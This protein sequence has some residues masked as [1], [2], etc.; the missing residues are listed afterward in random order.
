MLPCAQGSPY[1]FVE[2]LLAAPLAA[3]V[4]K[5]CMHVEFG[6]RHAM[7]KASCLLSENFDIGLRTRHCFESAELGGLSMG[8]HITFGSETCLAGA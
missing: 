8:S 3:L 7:P 2:F 1:G 4:H 5:P 6:R